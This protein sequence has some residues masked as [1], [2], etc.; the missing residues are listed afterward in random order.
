MKTVLACCLLAIAA[1][2]VLIC[3]MP[4]RRPSWK[5]DWG[6]V[7]S[8][9]AIVVLGAFIFFDILEDLVETRPAQTADLMTFAAMARLR[10]PTLDMVMT[11]VTE[12]GDAIVVAAVALGVAV[13]MAHV[14][15]WRALRYW[16]A[17]IVGAALINTAIKVA[18]HRPRP[19]D[20]YHHGWDAFSFPSGHSTSNVVLYGF[21]AVLL[22]RQTKPVP[23]LAIAL[24]SAMLVAV[25]GFSRL[26]L[27]AHWLSDV[28][29]GLAFGMAWI[30]GLHLLYIRKQPDGLRAGTLAI[31]A[32]SVL[33]VAG[34]LNVAV[35]Q[36]KD[37]KLYRSNAYAAHPAAGQTP[38]E[39]K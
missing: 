36:G 35:N 25:I 6:L 10:N 3:L 20:L 34:G 16:I 13:W 37:L 11:T 19:T 4:G 27:G 18:L 15:A 31:L 12:F 9:G 39:V 38:A 2:G 8:L 24:G 29:G 1:A 23:A 22:I 30:A 28:A 7:G 26:Y 14:H 17:A 33:V 5:R 21:L 32:F